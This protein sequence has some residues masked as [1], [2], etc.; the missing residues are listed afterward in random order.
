LKSVIITIIMSR[1]IK[2][3]VIIESGASVAVA[4]DVLTVKGPKGEIKLPIP[5]ASKLVLMGRCLGERDAHAKDT[6]LQGT[7]GRL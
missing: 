1:L 5:F 3:P 2:K 7:S 4:D 6:A